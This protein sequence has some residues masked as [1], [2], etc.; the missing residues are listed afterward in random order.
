MADA[1]GGYT[2]CALVKSD[3]QSTR[4]GGRSDRRSPL[5]DAKTTIPRRARVTVTFRSPL[6]TK[7]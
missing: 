2:L 4:Y 3:G 5:Y 1:G 6:F 7:P